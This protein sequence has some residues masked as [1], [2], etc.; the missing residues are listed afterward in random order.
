[1]RYGVTAIGLTIWMLQFLFWPLQFFSSI[2]RRLRQG[3]AM[4]YEATAIGS[5]IGS[6]I[7]T[8][9]G[10]TF[11]FVGAAGV[12]E[13]CSM[14]LEMTIAQRLLTGGIYSCL[15]LLVHAQ[16]KLFTAMTLYVSRS[17]LSLC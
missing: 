2:G 17:W 14:Q 11:L 9:L 10:L 8:L 15:V 6:T 5:A 1:M 16:W 13:A 4:R 3:A 7:W 12:S